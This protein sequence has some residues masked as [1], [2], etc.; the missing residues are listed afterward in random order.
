[1][2]A[3]GIFDV[4]FQV[5]RFG[6]QVYD[7]INPPSLIMNTYPENAIVSIDGVALKKHTP[8]SVPK[9]SAGLHEVVCAL[10]GFENINE[11]I[12]IPSGRIRKK[13]IEYIKP[14]S[15]RVQIES[16][17]AGASIL[18]ND[19]LL[20]EKTPYMVVKSVDAPL[21]LALSYDG[22]TTIEDF[23]IDLQSGNSKLK[24]RRVWNLSSKPDSTGV[25]SFIVT[26]HFFKN[27]QFN[28]NPP[29]AFIHIDG[30]DKSAGKSPKTI[31]LTAG[32]HKIT[33]K[34]PKEY[35]NFNAVDFN[36]TIDRR[37]PLR[38]DRQLRKSI[39]IRAEDFN[40]NE[41]PANLVFLNPGPSGRQY[42]PINKST[43]YRSTLGCFDSQLLLRHPDFRDT[44]AVLGM[45]DNALTVKMQKKKNWAAPD[46][47]PNDESKSE[48]KVSP[49]TDHVETVFQTKE[50]TSV[51][52]TSKVPET[53]AQITMNQGDANIT[54]QKDEK[55]KQAIL[56]S[57]ESVQVEIAVMDDEN[58]NNLEGVKIS[59]REAHSEDPYIS[60]GLTD[61]TGVKKTK[62]R[63]GTYDFLFQMAGYNDNVIRNHKVSEELG[64]GIVCNLTRN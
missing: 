1:M 62:I 10:E 11:V 47:K 2:L 15:R 33:M 55:L 23:E 18:I 24:D 32:D 42:E 16:N 27:V 48:V 36:L 43:P 58:W 39:V 26:G 20:P 28:S 54:E 21:R 14:F 19:L 5:T 6:Q 50:E 8:V 13:P 4:L 35:P 30:E 31:T 17:P 22:F 60:I 56:G 41:I 25:L 40:G 12:D 49:S 53:P 57:E 38:I 44:S 9:L 46:S 64:S 29:G 37:T 7:I 59:V 63:P 51:M 45:N 52:E 3:W 61:Q 34:P